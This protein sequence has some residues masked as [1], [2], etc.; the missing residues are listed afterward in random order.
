L[1]SKKLSAKIR[2]R[3]HIH[4]EAKHE[5]EESVTHKL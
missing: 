5:K 2:L 4:D 1:V 3:K